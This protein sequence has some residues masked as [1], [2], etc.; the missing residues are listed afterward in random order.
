MDSESDRDTVLASP[1]SSL[2]AFVLWHDCS[3]PSVPDKQI[4]IRRVG[5]SSHVWELSG[6]C[7]FSLIEKP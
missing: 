4:S 1:R 6:V 5:N 2:Q 7:V 3:C